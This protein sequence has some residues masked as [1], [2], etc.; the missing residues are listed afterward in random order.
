MKI[1]VL[2]GGAWGT[3]IAQTIAQGGTPVLLWAHEQEVVD[4]INKH[5]T[6]PFL[7]D[8][9]LSHN[10][11]ATHSLDEFFNQTTHVFEAVPVAFLGS[12][13]ERVQT[14]VNHTFIFLSKGINEAGLVPTEIVAS[15]GILNE[16][17]IMMGPSF[18][19]DLARKQPTG[20]SLYATEK[21]LYET[22]KKLF[23]NGYCVIEAADD[24]YAMQ[25][26]SAVKNIIALGVGIL[27]GAGYQDN[28][29]ILYV[30][31]S[32]E[33]LKQLLRACDASESVVYQYAG[34]GDSMLTALGTKSRN[35]S[36]GRLIG[37]G[38]SY[39]TII[40][41]H[42]T[43][44]EGINTVITVRALCQKKAIEIPLFEHL[45]TIVYQQGDSNLLLQELTIHQ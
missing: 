28:T 33:V 37:Q 41:E 26:C 1:G 36:A 17:A 43:V 11:T 9:I 20:F 42:Q 34:I 35:L 4:A 25:L 38:V 2:G 3:A 45:Y 16:Y 21:K 5:H 10:L 32:I 39:Q 6:N 30:M 24:P 14:T 44:A 8:I 29:K 40:K 19:A 23:N 12:V 31:K 22:I 7:K 18:A 15:L 27:D 13:F